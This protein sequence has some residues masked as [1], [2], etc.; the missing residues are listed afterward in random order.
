MASQV[1]YFGATYDDI[2]YRFNGSIVTDFATN[3]QTGDIVI[4]KEMDLVE[5]EILSRL[6]PKLVANLS[7]V[8]KVLAKYSELNSNFSVPF[9]ISSKT[10][11]HVYKKTALAVGQITE[12][13]IS[14]QD[15]Q[16]DFFSTAEEIS[17]SLITISGTTFTISGYQFNKDDQFYVS[18]EPTVSSEN[19]PSLKKILLDEIG[20]AHV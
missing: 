4:K 15:C 8:D 1:N 14:C 16:S 13:T 7:Y 10:G 2:L 12:T 9:S 17:Q 20:R 6:N 11:M 19:L 5:S 3:S 18:Y